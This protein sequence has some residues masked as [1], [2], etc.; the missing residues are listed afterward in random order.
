MSLHLGK[1]L[2]ASLLN[3][4]VGYAVVSPGSRNAPLLEA[5]ADSELKLLPIIDERQAAFIALGIAR[6]TRRPVALCCTSGS[7][8]LNYAPALSEAFYSG[9][10]LIVI[11]A[12][13]P[14]G[15]AGQNVGQT[16]RQPGSLE[17]VVKTCLIVDFIVVNQSDANLYGERI[18]KTIGMAIDGFAGPVHINIH[19]PEPSTIHE[20][21]AAES[22]DF[23]P[24]ASL[25]NEINK[26]ETVDL[27]P[28]RKVAVFV[29]PNPSDPTTM[30]FLSFLAAK[31]GVAVLGESA[32]NLPSSESIVTNIESSLS[33]ADSAV[34]ANL[35]PDLLITL[36]GTPTSPSWRK[37]ISETDRLTHWDVSLSDDPRDTYG[38]LI[39]R[40]RVAP[41]DFFEALTIS[42]IDYRGDGEYSHGWIELSK[43][44]YR[45][46]RPD[47]WEAT[48]I[49]N[50]LL[51]KLEGDCNL[52]LSNGLS[53]RYANCSKYSRK[54][55]EVFA[56][57]GVSGIEGSVSTAMGCALADSDRPTVLICGDMS[58]FYDLSA[59]FSPYFSQSGLKTIILNNAGGDIFRKIPST[60]RSPI[61]ENVLCCAE[62]M[63]DWPRMLASTDIEIL[64][65]ND[66]A[67]LESA[68]DSMNR[69]NKAMILIINL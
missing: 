29:G 30:R 53:L 25:P 44:A 58:A 43:K 46:I 19:L 35:A 68:V 26:E 67:S 31:P 20:I 28:Y 24:L 15:Q 57:R 23:T 50:Q 6:R 60:R 49:V 9:V 18:Y 4:G 1:I 59:F 40:F 54:F 56:N 55:R 36:G 65:A 2:I 51:E 63:P 21:P 34:I 38:K 42:N 47:T 62:Q 39:R 14:A 11:S 66:Y 37:M 41:A 3:Q 64:S 27:S 22:R 10:P 45:E 12:D 16:I 17:S 69:S 5:M 7:A 52:H 61:V 13:R 33:R 48:N 32:S 8:L